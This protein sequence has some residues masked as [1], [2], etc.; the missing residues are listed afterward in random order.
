MKLIPV[1]A[2]L[3]SSCSE[4]KQA[5]NPSAPVKGDE[6]A[7]V[8]LEAAPQEPLEIAEI[9]KSAKPGETVT[10]SGLVMGKEVV[11]MDSRAV[12]T[13]GDPGKMTPCGPEEGCETPWDVCCDDPEV[14]NA[15]I[16]TVQVV[17]ENGKVLKKGLKGVGGMTELSSLTVTG[18]VAEGSNAD[19]MV[20]N[21]TGIFVTPKS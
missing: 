11:F 14:V 4:E 15:A 13:L 21:A 16:I 17:D 12:L 3:L 5:D 6:L 7:A 10:F 2:V 1:L 8:L 18:E 20:V 19:N 9:R